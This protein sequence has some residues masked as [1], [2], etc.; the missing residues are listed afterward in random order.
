MQTTTYSGLQLILYSILSFLSIGVSLAFGAATRK[1]LLSIATALRLVIL[2]LIFVVG[3]ILLGLREQQLL[4]LLILF[5]APTAV[6]SYP[7]AVAMG[8]DGELAG[9]L[10]AVSTLLCL[11]TIFLWT[12]VLNML[13][14]L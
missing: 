3:G 12:M 8:A 1:G 4:S 6:S 10:V 13:Q 11:P 9:Q 7:M 2:P 5:G 14:L